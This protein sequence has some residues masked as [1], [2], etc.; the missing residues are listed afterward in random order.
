MHGSSAAEGVGVSAVVTAQGKHVAVA[1]GV[2]GKEFTINL[3]E[4]KL[5]STDSP[6]L[7]DL[8]LTLE[9]DEEAPVTTASQP[10]ETQKVGRIAAS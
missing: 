1:E 9:S 6:H 8:D 3:P 2:V 10:D 7:Y 5:W 4:P